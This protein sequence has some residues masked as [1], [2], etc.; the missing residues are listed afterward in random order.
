MQKKKDKALGASLSTMS[1]VVWNGDA[2]A[3]NTKRLPPL[4]SDTAAEE[5][6]RAVAYN[7]KK[8]GEIM[9]HKMLMRDNKL[10]VLFSF[11]NA[12]GM[13]T[14][15]RDY[16]NN[17]IHQ[18]FIRALNTDLIRQHS[19][20]FKQGDSVQIKFNHADVEETRVLVEE[21]GPAEPQEATILCHFTKENKT[22]TLSLLPED[23][24]LTIKEELSKI[25]SI[26]KKHMKLEVDG[27]N[28]KDSKA[29]HK[30]T[31]RNLTVNL[32]GKAKPQET[33][34]KLDVPNDLPT[35]WTRSDIKKHFRTLSTVK[36]RT[37]IVD[38]IGISGSGLL[39]PASL[40]QKKVKQG[41]HSE[42]YTDYIAHKVIAAYLEIRVLMQ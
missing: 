28:L 13:G 33:R 32:S 42:G 37:G 20:K 23:T 1:F 21:S 4:K 29:V 35:K 5:N 31:S 19:D 8:Y 11:N 15:L 30:Y 22:I 18:Y 9:W 27:K 36:S 2:R 25:T 14:F 12:K 7:I 17:T 6:L 38:V 26:D 34:I 39:M 24:T 10:F 40:L 3:K 41:C 16:D